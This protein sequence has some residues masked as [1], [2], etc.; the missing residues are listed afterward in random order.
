MRQEINIEPMNPEDLA[1]A[2]EC[3][4]TEGWISENLDL[5]EDFYDHDPQGC[6]IA[7]KAGEPVGICIATAYNRS[8]F[9]GELIVRADLR[10]RGIGGALLN[11]AVVYLLAR[12]ARS[13]YLDGVVTAVP[14]Y[15]RRGFRRI[16]RSMRF[17]G[18][19]SGN[20]H[21]QVR[22]MH[23]KDMAQVIALDRQAF[24]DDRSFFLNRR[25]DR[26]PR[27]CLVEVERAEVSGYLMGRRGRG[28]I[29]A[30]PGV[31]SSEAGNPLPLLETFAIHAEEKGFS[32]GVL[33]AN[34]RASELLRSLG[35]SKRRDSPWR[36]VLGPDDDLGSIKQCYAI[37]SPAKG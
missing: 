37:G 22:A 15:E 33:E 17:S 7:R 36:M 32:I 35:L 27:L 24:G 25:L 2:V 21:P 6:I 12:G 4:A 16:C 23:S 19:I 11:H 13:I 34:T 26:C 29:S 1:F 28:F 18:K 3:T 10:Q 9:I 30:G 14:F 5:F 20:Q 31:L 8:G